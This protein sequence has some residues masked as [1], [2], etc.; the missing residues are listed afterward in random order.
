MDMKQI[1]KLLL[2]FAPW[3]AFLILSG[4]SM[5]R[6]EIS[7]VA[8][9]VITV[10]MAVFKLH[11]GAIVWAGFAFFGAALVMVLGFKNMWFIGHIG[12]LANGTLLFST[13]I[14]MLIGRPFTEEYAKAEVAPEVWETPGFVRSC[15]ISTSLWMLVFL[16]N[17]LADI[18]KEDNPQISSWKFRV[19]NYAMLLSGVAAT[20]LFTKFKRR[21]REQENL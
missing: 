9:G 17:F 11:R 5:L 8:A 21:R 1:F 2:A 12:L 20:S 13:I 10:L 15:Y 6:L 19:F 16:L 14:S 18:V 3:L 4:P 7:L